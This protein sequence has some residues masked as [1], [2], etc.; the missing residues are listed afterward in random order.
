MSSLDNIPKERW[1]GPP[2]GP[3]DRIPP[4]GRGCS[5]VFMTI[6]GAILLLPGLCSLI[7]GLGLIHF[8]SRPYFSLFMAGM[9]LGTL[10]ILLI[11]MA[12]RRPPPPDTST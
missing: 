10:G 1:R 5:T 3:P 9:V 6:A 11:R 12:W 2:E 7:Y 8:Y 4:P